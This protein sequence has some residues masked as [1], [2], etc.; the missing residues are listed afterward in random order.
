MTGKPSDA[1]EVHL[2]CAICFAYRHVCQRNDE[3]C[4]I[5]LRM[6]MIDSS[7]Y[8][9]LYISVCLS[10]FLPCWRINV[11][12]SLIHC[13][14]SNAFSSF[15][16]CRLYKKQILFKR[17]LFTKP[18]DD[19]FSDVNIYKLPLWF[20]PGNRYQVT[21]YGRQHEGRRRAIVCKD[22]IEFRTGEGMF[23]F[24]QFY[25]FLSFVR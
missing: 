5:S 6:F 21:V 14:A 22:S 15:T 23:N 4:Y 12:I 7:F 17:L 9:S 20:R 19:L 25:V 16:S 13:S 2:R 1:T 3:N 8:L 10:V 24:C 11:F 18:L